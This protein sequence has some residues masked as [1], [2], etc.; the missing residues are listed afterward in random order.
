MEG[1]LP[2]PTRALPAEALSYWRVQLAVVAGVGLVV[3]LGVSSPLPGPWRAL[4]LLAYVGL[5]GAAVVVLPTLRHRRWRYE[6]RE[7]KIDI[8]HGTFVVTRTV[9]PIR[10]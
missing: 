9:V 6:V 5:A 2:D 7:Q 8:R 10:R 4:A 1:P 3:L